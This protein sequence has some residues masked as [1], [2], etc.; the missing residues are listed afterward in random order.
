MAVLAVL[1]ACATTP[2][3]PPPAP[4]VTGN[5]LADLDGHSVGYDKVPDWKTEQGCQVRSAVR[6]KQTSVAWTHPVLMSCPLAMAL[7]TFETKVVQPAARRTL[8]H[9]VTH[10]ANAG[11]YACRPINGE[12]TQRL[13]EHAFG[14]AIDVTGFELDDGTRISVLRDWHG[15]GPK[16]VFLHEV[17]KDA[18]SYFRVVLSPN[19]NALHRDHL[20]LDLGPYTLCGV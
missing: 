9:T 10:I 16:S 17:A 1:A 3:P 14:L 8:S 19:H 12:K 11:T 7:W 15:D 18:C 13:S 4:V 2:P 6:L 20:H 5:C